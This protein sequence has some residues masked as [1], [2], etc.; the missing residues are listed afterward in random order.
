MMLAGRLEKEEFSAAF[1][2][3]IDRHE[4]LRT[5]FSVINGVEVQR[6][7]K[8]NEV[9]FKIEYYENNEWNKSAAGDLQHGI[10]TL[11]SVNRIIER[12][13]RPFDLAQAPLFRVGLF[14]FPHW[15]PGLSAAENSGEERFMLMIDMHHIISDGASMG[16]LIRD[17]T[18]IYRGEELPPLKI[19]YKDFAGWQDSRKKE[20]ETRKQ[21]AYWLEQFS[22]KLPALRLPTDFP[23]TAIR[24]TAG[25][26]LFFEIEGETTAALKRMVIDQE[27][28]L[29]I[30]LLTFY[31]VFLKKVSS[32]EDIVIGTPTAGR[33]HPDLEP[34]IGMFVNTLGLRNYPRGDMSFR[35]FL[36]GVKKHTL[37]AF[38]NQ[39]FQF[40]DLVE[41]LDINRDMSRNVLFDTMFSLQ[42]IEI[43]EIKIPG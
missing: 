5:Y 15:F 27:T 7:K 9:F 25:R 19:Q 3:L 29:Y 32:Q 23:R 42:N 22:G 18:A 30:I 31:Y 8:T 21:E 17:F 24:N 39:D 38:G 26:T 6:I 14:R 34:V 43:G 4:S 33:L 1:K 35:E 28:T 13:I 40:E 11:D 10:C 41:K 36:A 2:K 16:V 37:A 20:E 12:F